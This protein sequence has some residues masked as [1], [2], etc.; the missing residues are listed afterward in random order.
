MR[1]FLKSVL[2]WS[3]LSRVQLNFVSGPRRRCGCVCL[4]FPWRIFVKCSLFLVRLNI[5]CENPAFRSVTEVSASANTKIPL[6][7]RSYIRNM[8]NNFRE[9]MHFVVGCLV[10]QLLIPLHSSVCSMLSTE[11]ALQTWH[12]VHVKLWHVSTTLW[13]NHP[14]EQSP[15]YVWGTKLY[16]VG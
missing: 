4:S 7:V 6:K 15:C 5:I 12:Y 11:R 10:L 16:Y 1:H 14:V 9:V 13:L 2:K 8:H 3:Q